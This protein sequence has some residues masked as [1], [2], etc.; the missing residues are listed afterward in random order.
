MKPS[1]IIAVGMAMSAMFDSH[2]YGMKQRKGDRSN[3][4]LP[5]FNFEHDGRN[6][7]IQA[8]NEA[9]AKLKF[10]KIIKRKTS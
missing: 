7:S 2:N 4:H 8:I 6:Y 5:Y 3:N 10:E 9:S 1:E